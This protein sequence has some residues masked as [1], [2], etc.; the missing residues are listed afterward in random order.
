[1][2]GKVEMS[3]GLGESMDRK[4]EAMRSLRNCAFAIVV[5]VKHGALWQYR[6]MHRIV[7]VVYV[8]K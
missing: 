1:M 3:T 2:D 5:F 4:L 8:I 7:L 6:T